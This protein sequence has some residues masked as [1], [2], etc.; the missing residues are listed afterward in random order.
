[1][2]VVTG[3]TPRFVPVAG[4]ALEFMENATARVFREPTD[5][6][7]YILLSGRWFRSWTTVGPWQYIPSDQL[8][9]DFAKIPASL[10]K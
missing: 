9:A 2:L 4:T 3:G 8:P 7:L 1:V 6:E 10:L 5:H